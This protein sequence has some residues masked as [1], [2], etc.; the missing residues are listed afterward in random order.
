MNILFNNNDKDFWNEKEK[1]EILKINILA[2][3]ISKLKRWLN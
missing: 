2:K 1:K 3:I